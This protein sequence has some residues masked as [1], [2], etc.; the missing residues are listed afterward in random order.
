M[1]T[2]EG[3]K[4]TAAYPDRA[5]ELRPLA[6]WPCFSFS[7]AFSLDA[8]NPLACGR[9]SCQWATDGSLPSCDRLSATWLKCSSSGGRSK[10][11]GLRDRRCTRLRATISL[12]I[13]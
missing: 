4:P 5:L 6:G 1:M 11:S 12:E 2:L 3:Q 7:H 8:R 10:A 9:A 13:G